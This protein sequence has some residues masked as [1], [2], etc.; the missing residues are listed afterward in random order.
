[1][2]GEDVVRRVE[3]QGRVERALREP[4]GQG[5]QARFSVYADDT[6]TPYL[7]AFH[8][9]STKGGLAAVLDAFDALLPTADPPALRYALV[10][11]LASDPEARRLGVRAPGPAAPRTPA[12]LPPDERTDP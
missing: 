11:W 12:P 7:G 6:W 2:G 1:M 4:P 8:R 9:A 10:V 5:P 3:L